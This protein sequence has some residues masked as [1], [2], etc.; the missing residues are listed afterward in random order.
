ML[1]TA[2]TCDADIYKCHP[3]LFLP[4]L[5][6]WLWHLPC[7]PERKVS[8]DKIQKGVCVL[9]RGVSSHYRHLPVGRLAAAAAAAAAA[10]GFPAAGLLLAAEGTE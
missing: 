8:D 9:W 10:A 5:H 2:V 1:G 3:S 7:I 4:D 6:P